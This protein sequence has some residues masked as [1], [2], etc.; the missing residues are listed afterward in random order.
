MDI[1][2]ESRITQMSQRNSE[3]MQWNKKF[4]SLASSEIPVIDFII[5]KF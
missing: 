3:E 4:V 2:S 5:K 1:L